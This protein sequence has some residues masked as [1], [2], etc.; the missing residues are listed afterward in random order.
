MTIKG[1][2]EAAIQH[3]IRALAILNSHKTI[4]KYPKFIL[5]TRCLKLLVKSLSIIND[6][7]KII[8]RLEPPK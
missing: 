8:N 4:G 2:L 6:C 3:L 5:G 7:V 1:E